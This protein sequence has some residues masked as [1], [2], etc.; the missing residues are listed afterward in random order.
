LG[1]IRDRALVRGITNRLRVGI[2]RAK[3]LTKLENKEDLG[4]LI[5]FKERYI[6]GYYNVVI[7]RYFLTDKPYIL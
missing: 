2:L 7:R 3:W 6:K 4:I 1:C 5:R